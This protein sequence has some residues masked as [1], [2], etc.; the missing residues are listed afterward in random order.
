VE[1][2]NSSLRTSVFSLLAALLALAGAPAGAL[3]IADTKPLYFV[4]P[5][6]YGFGA[7]EV[8]AAGLS[9]TLEADAEDNWIDAG[10][11]KLGLPIAIE[12]DLQ[13][14]HKNPQAR[15]RKPN[16]R[17]PIIADSTW[18]ITNHTG[19]ALEDAVLVFSLGDTAGRKKKKPVALDGNLVE[20]LAYSFGGEDYLLGAV[21]LGDLAAEGEGSSISID[22]RYIVAGRLA[23][24]GSKLLLP[25][26]GVSGLTGWSP[27]PE[28]GTASLIG[29]GLLALA[30][31]RR[32]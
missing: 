28:P 17:K 13:K 24:R 19:E 7:A 21:R 3:T 10:D 16:A 32:G 30:A 9:P 26:L 8:T 22:V 6:G 11:A 27:I 23:R 31:R 25:P 12:V 15:G 2:T 29:L 4:G 14:V 1:H 18:T 20:I 5:G